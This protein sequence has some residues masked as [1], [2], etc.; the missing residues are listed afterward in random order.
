MQVA[1]FNTI[2]S[3][4]EII[5][6]TGTTWADLQQELAIKNIS[7]KGMSAIIGE[8]Q[9]TLDQPGALLPTGDFSL[10]LL[11]IEVKSGYHFDEDASFDDDNDDFGNDDDSAE[12]GVTVSEPI[13]LLSIEDQMFIQD[14]RSAI[15]TLEAVIARTEK[16]KIT[17]PHILER[18]RQA[19]ILM[20]NRR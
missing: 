13:P 16:R 6:I 19:A 15:T 17:D 10:F 5:N 9:V 7:Y 8:T 2:G 18:Q 14:C 3:N 4:E 1:V 11:P 20:S 12:F